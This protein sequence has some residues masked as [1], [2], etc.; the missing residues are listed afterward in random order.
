MSKTTSNEFDIRLIDYNL[1]NGKIDKKNLDKHLAS[2][3]DSADNLEYV[4]MNE[5]P[6]SEEIDDMPTSDLAFS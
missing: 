4:D 3:P 6:A 1:N 2:L 5:E